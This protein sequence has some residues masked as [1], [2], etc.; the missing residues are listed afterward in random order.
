MEWNQCIDHSLN[1]MNT[2]AVDCRRR[3]S[4]CHFCTCRRRRRRRRR[5]CWGGPPLLTDCLSTNCHPP[6]TGKLDGANYLQAT[7][8]LW[9]ERQIDG[10]G[11]AYGYIKQG[12]VA[13]SRA[14]I[15]RIKYECPRPTHNA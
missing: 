5:H 10:G 7:V 8:A 9:A 3:R 11:L 15:P 6:A 4:W 14:I 12:V 13:L 1:G 2:Y